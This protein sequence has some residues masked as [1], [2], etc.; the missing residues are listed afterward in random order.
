MQIP[1]TSKGL[2]VAMHCFFTSFEV[3]LPQLYSA[4]LTPL[5][6]IDLHLHVCVQ[7]VKNSLVPM[8][9]NK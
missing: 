4:V 5:R 8:Y 2:N 1:M 3:F 7:Q 6:K 9:E